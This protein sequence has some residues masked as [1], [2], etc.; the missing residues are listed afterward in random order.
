MENSRKI[1]SLYV[2][3]VAFN[4]VGCYNQTRMV[5]KGLL[6]SFVDFQNQAMLENMEYTLFNTNANALAIDFNNTL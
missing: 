2:W 1:T 6:S 4:M 5:M 3:L